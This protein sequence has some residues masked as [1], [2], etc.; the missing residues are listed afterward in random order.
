MQDTNV[1]LELLHERGKKGLPLERVYRQ[2]FN[3][4]LYLTAYGKI[5]RNAGALTPG[6]TP[7]TV[8][9]MSL[10]KIDTIIEAL[11]YERYRWKPARRTSIPKK[12]GKKRPLGLPVWSDKLLAEVIRMILEAYFEPRFSDHSHGF[13]PG[14][15]C[16]TALREIYHKWHAT[17]W[18]IEGDISGCF[19]N[20]N[21]EL[22]LSTLSEHIHDGRFIRLMRQLLDAG[23]LEDWKWHR[24]YSGVPQGSIVSP[25]LSN[26]LLDKLDTFVE[27]VLIPKYTRGVD[28]K[29]HRRYKRLLRQA[30]RLYRKGQ[31]KAARAVRKQAQRMPSRD[32]HDPNYRRLK[33]CRYADD[34][35]LGFVGP[36]AEAEEIKGLLKQFLREELKLELS[37][38]KTL[39]THARSEAARFLGYEVTTIQSDTKRLRPK[40][41]RNRRNVNGTIGLRVPKEIIKDKCNRYK[42]NGKVRHRTELLNETDYTIIRTYQSEFR[43]IAN[44]Y[45]LAY[46]LHTLN[47]LKWTM[48]QSLTKTL[49]H[50]HNISVRKV[51]DRY[52]TTVMSNETTYKALEVTVPRDGKRSLKATWG[53]ISLKWDIKAT[54]ED[55]ARPHFWSGRSELEKRLLAQVCEYCGANRQADRIEVH[56]IRALKDLDQYPGREKPR[57]IKLMATRRRKTMVLCRTCHQDLHAGR[58]MRRQTIKF[59]KASTGTT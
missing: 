39:I 50:K 32:P 24:T 42:K 45:R 6:V 15:G 49:A 44:Y 43:G 46:N 3:R 18:F 1:Y 56:H 30:D 13:R 47:P 5:Y 16:H 17:T 55:R 36:K 25:I 58:P 57:W 48:E 9:A 52:Q 31:V 4:K 28:R 14:R 51:Y 41:G 35:L 53:G 19:D 12:N 23:Y 7:E 37:S 59:M 38:S 11:R 26:I 2:L 21:H 40:G 29:G 20:L 10:E 54:L 33:Y 8:D 34:F 22:L 27:T